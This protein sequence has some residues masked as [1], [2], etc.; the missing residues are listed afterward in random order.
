[1]PIMPW[2][3]PCLKRL[4]FGPSEYGVLCVLEREGKGDQRDKMEGGETEE[5]K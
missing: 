5:Y 4:V 1:M 2:T 3:G